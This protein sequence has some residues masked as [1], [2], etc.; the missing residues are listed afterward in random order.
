MDFKLLRQA[1][2]KFPTGVTVVTWFD[3]VGINGITVKEGYSVE[4]CCLV[5]DE[6]VQCWLDDHEMEKYLR[7][8]TLFRPS[9][10]ESYLNNALSK[11]DA[12][13]RMPKAIVLDFNAGEDW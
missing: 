4:D 1:F 13:T 10:F 5:I 12:Q 7:P 6:Q 9:N 2:G 8:M 11:K 3:D